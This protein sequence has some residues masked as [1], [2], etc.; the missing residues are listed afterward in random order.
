M[1]FW[2]RAGRALSFPSG[3]KRYEDL[4]TVSIE[5]LNDPSTPFY[6]ALSGALDGLGAGGGAIP[7]LPSL[8][9]DQA[10]RVSALYL[11]VALTCC[12]V[13]GMPL[14]TFQEDGENRSPIKDQRQRYLWRRPNDE[15]TRQEFWETVLAHR[16]LGGDAFLYVDRNRLGYPAQLHWIYPT[17]V[18]IGRDPASL[19]K[20]YTLDGNTDMPM[21][22]ANLYEGEIVHVRNLSWGRSGL[23]GFGLV[24]LA[25]T[26]IGIEQASQQYGARFFSNGSGPGGVI[27][28][29]ADWDDDTAERLS[30]RWERFHKGLNSSHKIAVLGNDG[31]YEQSLINPDDAQVLLTRNFQIKELARWFGVPPHLLMDPTGSTTWGSGL[32]EQNRAFVRFTL[33]RM[34]T[35]VEQAISDQ[36]CEDPR[37]VRWN[38]DA[39]LRG[40]TLQRYQAYNMARIAGFLSNNDIR[41][42]EDLAPIAPEDEDEYQIPLNSNKAAQQSSGDGS[43][44]GSGNADMQSQIDALKQQI[45]ELV[46]N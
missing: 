9:M 34:S 8:S 1:S 43:I 7:G 25:R 23:R 35:P 4:G 6:S 16:Q 22:T 33:A 3:G 5:G 38:Y 10:G 19:R 45:A 46:A 2:E 11:A 36:L 40:S 42:Y 17:R 39:L 28:S 13:A 30:R 24:H 27:T 18:Q 32:E 29:K 21:V 20:V 37:Y 15:E 26:G 14:Q 12:T 44:D 31:H 41:R